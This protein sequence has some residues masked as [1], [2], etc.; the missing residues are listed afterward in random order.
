M[1]LAPSNYAT[2]TQVAGYFRNVA[3]DISA[4]TGYIRQLV[5]KGLT[6][7]KTC[8]VL[9]TLTLTLVL[10]GTVVNIQ[11]NI[12]VC[13]AC[14]ET[15]TQGNVIAPFALLSIHGLLLICQPQRVGRL[16]WPS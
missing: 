14:P 10:N 1:L 3:W 6:G 2:N 12:I 15:L 4:G 5:A 13:P 7:Y 11:L 8:A 9:T 16:S